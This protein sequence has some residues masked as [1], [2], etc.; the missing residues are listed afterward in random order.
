MR[1]LI[2]AR[3]IVFQAISNCSLNPISIHSRGYLSVFV[4]ARE[5]EWIVFILQMEQAP[6]EEKRK[7]NFHWMLK[8]AS[9]RFVCATNFSSRH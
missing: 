4:C 9:E 2:K 5:R 6:K 8:V 7:I 1:D 3:S